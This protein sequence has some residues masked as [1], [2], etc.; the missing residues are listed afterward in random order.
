MTSGSYRM[1]VNS[2]TKIFDMFV[3]GTFTPTDVENFVRDYNNEVNR[4]NASEY[5]LEIDCTSMDLLKPEMVPSLENSY[6]MYKESGFKEVVFN[7]KGN[8]VL[9]LQ[10]SRLA[11]NTGLTNAEVR[12]V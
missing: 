9:K 4:I 10:L 5:V 7:I 11:R 3:G 2:S 12:V 1:K 6:R 8:A